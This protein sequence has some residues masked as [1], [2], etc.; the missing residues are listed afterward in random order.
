MT[1][2]FTGQILDDYTGHY[3]NARY[4]ACPERRRRDPEIGRFI[5]PDTI[6]PTAADPQGL[7]R[8]SYCN[9]N[10]LN[11]TDPSGHDPLTVAII[12][13][14]VAVVVNVAVAA[15]TGGDIGKAAL[16]GFIGGLVGVVGGFIASIALSTVA[17][18]LGPVA[19]GAIV[20]AVG[21]AAGGAASAAVSGGDVG[22]GALTGAVGGAIGGAA[23]GWTKDWGNSWRDL[24]ARGAVA[25]CSGALAGGVTAAIA[26][27]N[28]WQG[29]A[30]GAAGAAVAF[31]A[32]VAME[33]NGDEIAAEVKED[34]GSFSPPGRAPGAWKQECPNSCVA[35]TTVEAI[36]FATDEDV[37]EGTVRNELDAAAGMKNHNWNVEGMDPQY[38]VPVLRAH[39]VSNARTISPAEISGA[40]KDGNAVMA[41]INNPGGK[42]TH[43]V[44]IRSTTVD[45]KGNVTYHG[46]DQGVVKSWQASDVNTTWKP[47]LI[48]KGR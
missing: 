12:I 6:V 8:Y 35:G 15:A 1:F 25:V 43:E 3:Y 18:T 44:L 20:G 46:H 37:P 22:M 28:I 16:A 11:S 41:T 33:E 26:G 14:V 48:P 9:N 17:A 38:A 21:G 32:T 31:A 39:G 19:T 42:T 40:V 2:Q 36:K 23:G 13:I 10:P 27:G 5:Q 7:N 24:A 30:T 29:M 47:V 34:H 45:A 4:G